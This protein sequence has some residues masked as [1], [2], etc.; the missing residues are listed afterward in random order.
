MGGIAV[1]S[2]HFIGNRAVVLGNGDPAFQILYSSRYTVISFFLPV[3]VVF[4]AFG[5][6]GAVNDN[7]SIV[8]LTL[9]GSLAGLG[10]CGMHYL[11]QAGISNYD[12][13]HNSICVVGAVVIA[14]LASVG[15][16]V[17]FFV[18]RNSWNT[19]WWKRACC[20]LLLAAAVSGMHWVASIGTYYRLRAIDPDVPVVLSRSLLVV[21]VVILVSKIPFLSSVLQF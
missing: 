12:C 21:I 4:V 8:R 9:G 17:I 3:A 1:W 19:A 20:G 18:Y 10:I 2:M 15:A 7:L 13:I 5:T 16:L 6:T 11:G 14:I